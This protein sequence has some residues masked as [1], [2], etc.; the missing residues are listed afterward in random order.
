[1]A[2]REVDAHILNMREWRQAYTI[3]PV[4]TLTYYGIVEQNVDYFRLTGRALQ[5][6]HR[7]VITDLLGALYDGYA[8]ELTFQIVVEPI[9][10]PDRYDYVLQ[11]LDLVAQ[12]ATELSGYRRE[13]ELLG[14]RLSVVVRFGSEMNDIEGTAGTTNAAA[15]VRAY[16]A[17]RELFSQ[18]LPRAPFPFSPALR[19]DLEVAPIAAYWPGTDCVDLVGATWYVHGEDQRDA[20]FSR[21]REY[22]ETFGRYDL[23]R[24]LDEFGGAEGSGSCYLDNDCM[25]RKMFAH[26]ES[27]AAEGMRFTYGTIFLDA[28]K[29]GVDAALRFLA[30]RPD[31]QDS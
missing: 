5:P 17:V 22:F 29:Y 6:K 1:M 10:N 15:F 23:P 20:S 24:S 19:A 30:E 16:R 28:Q 3:L 8:T 11:H 13:A 4:G 14:K 27:L 31:G 21:M 26:I 7:S 12:I 2:Y 18:I 9:Q 25:L